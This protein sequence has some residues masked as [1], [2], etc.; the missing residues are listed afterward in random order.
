MDQYNT[1][2]ENSARGS[3][4]TT[5][6]L[7]KAYHFAVYHPD[8]IVWVVAASHVHADE[9]KHQLKRMFGFLPKNLVFTT[10]ESRRG[11]SSHLSYA[12]FWD[13]YAAERQFEK[14]LKVAQQ[15][16]LKRVKDSQ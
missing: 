15:E 2:L 5:R 13:H 11:V 8:D 16:Y 4:R 12:S 7:D 10:I 3:G 1:V 6:M 14:D 9:L